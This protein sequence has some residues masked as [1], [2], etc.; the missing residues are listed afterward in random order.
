MQGYDD[1]LPRGLQTIDRIDGNKDYSPE[2]CRL[3]TIA[4][5]QRNKD[6]LKKYSYKGEKH[7]LCEWAEILGLDFNLLRS[8]VCDYGWSIEQ[9]LTE[10]KYLKINK[11]VIKITYKGESITI[12]EWSE[13]LGISA[14]TIRGRMN[15]YDEP[16]KILKV[17]KN[18]RTKRAES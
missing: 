5:Q 11:E 10:E 8:R 16:E 12:K 7:L 17:G 2:N 9:S 1:S 14:N 4:E 15:Y 13:K 18:K 3:I 6:C